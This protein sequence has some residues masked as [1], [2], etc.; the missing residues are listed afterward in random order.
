M[1]HNSRNTVTPSVTFND[2]SRVERA[3]TSCEVNV[4][5]KE[6]REERRKESESWA[7]RSQARLSVKVRRFDVHCLK[8]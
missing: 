8:G 4:M 3:R 6:A 5:M 7:S 2:C 1:A